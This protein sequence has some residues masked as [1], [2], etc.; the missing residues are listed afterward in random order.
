MKSA[1]PLSPQLQQ[2]SDKFC[3]IVIAH[4]GHGSPELRKARDEFLTIYYAEL[5]PQEN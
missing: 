1:W 4:G 2:A 3:A 5:R